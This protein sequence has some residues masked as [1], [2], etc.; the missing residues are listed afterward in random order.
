MTRKKE[1][2]DINLISER[3]KLLMKKEELSSKQFAGIFN[4][5]EATVSK[6]LNKRATPREN[7]LKE[8]SEHFGEKL[9]FFTDYNYFTDTALN[10]DFT[11]KDDLLEINTFI[12]YN[13]KFYE[14]YVNSIKVLNYIYKNQEHLK[15]DNNMPQFQETLERMWDNV[16]TD[17]QQDEFQK[18]N[19]II[20]DM[21]KLV[22]ENL[23]TNQ[24]QYVMLDEN[25]VEDFLA[26]FHK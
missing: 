24:K 20:F 14:M 6:W 22:D 7:N 12:K 8:I 21:K 18:I 5:T 3:L 26:Q 1:K 13:Q 16:L 9:S 19:R 25:N 15:L 10:P 11:T 4:Y 17:R 2:L 23:A